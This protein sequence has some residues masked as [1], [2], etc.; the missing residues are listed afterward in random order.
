MSV[1][2]ERLAE[3]W[4]RAVLNWLAKDGLNPFFFFLVSTAVVC[5]GNL[6]VGDI[7]SC[8]TRFAIYGS[9]RL[10]APANKCLLHSRLA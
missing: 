7:G 4:L 3:M 5:D 2:P 9:C 6:K 8:F 10:R 1:L